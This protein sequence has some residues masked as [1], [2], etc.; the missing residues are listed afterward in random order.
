[1]EAE[2]LDQTVDR[3]A[4]HTVIPSCCERGLYCMPGHAWVYSLHL[5]A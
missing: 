4:E 2:P 3:T 5:S 1:M